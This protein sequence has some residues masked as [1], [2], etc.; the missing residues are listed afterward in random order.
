MRVGF[1][2]T[3]LRGAPGGVRTAIR[4]VLEALAKHAPEVDVV[5]LAPREVDLPHG[6]RMK[7]TGGP[8]KPRYWRRIFDEFLSEDPDGGER[9]TMGLG[10][11][12]E[13]GLAGYLLGE[14]RAVE[15]GSEPCGWIFAVGVDARE[16]RKG[17]ANA[18]LDHA[19][20]RFRELG[21][22]VLRTMVRRN[23]V[24][25]LTFFRS[26]GFV[27]GSFAQLEFDLDVNTAQEG[28]AQESGS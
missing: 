26:G 15:F 6:I 21:V 27:G 28:T 12:G 8:T 14:V 9:H 19:K 3:E 24:P 23:D 25:V 7:A 1:D 11:D 20:Q 13:P 16:L 22:T 4:L 2:V 17:I 18:L 10:A 5:A